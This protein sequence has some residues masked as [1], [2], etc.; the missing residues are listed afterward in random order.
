MK[1]QQ[2]KNTKLLYWVIT[3]LFSLFMLFSSI[4]DILNNPD[5]VKFMTHLG[6]PLYRDSQTIGDNRDPHS[7]LSA[8]KRM[9][10]CGSDL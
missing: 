1:N 4:P 9:G 5:A 7:R 8:N 3:I 2:M 10:L 6:Y